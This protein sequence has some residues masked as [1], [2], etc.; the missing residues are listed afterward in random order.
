MH[1]F[2][3]GLVLGQAEEVIIIVCA[4]EDPIDRENVNRV[5]TRYFQEGLSLYSTLE[6]VIWHTAQGI[7]EE[8]GCNVVTVTADCACMIPHNE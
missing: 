8:C 6:Q 7:T 3:L 1:T 4:S 5:A 2:N